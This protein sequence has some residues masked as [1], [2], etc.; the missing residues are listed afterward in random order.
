IAA[1][2]G[3]AAV[4]ANDWVYQDIRATDLGLGR[5]G[6]LDFPQMALSANAL[7]V[8]VNVLTPKLLRLAHT[9]II[10]LALDDLATGAPAPFESY[11][12][13]NRR[14]FAAAQG[15]AGTMDFVGSEPGAAEP[16]R[17]PG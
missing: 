8:T 16:P 5:R 17:C 11:T 6:V 13:G 9:A 4:A 14:A 3:A 7:F 15:A 2:R 10:R 12:A 1:A